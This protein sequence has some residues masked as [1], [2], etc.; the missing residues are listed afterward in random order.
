MWLSH[1]HSTAQAP[2]HGRAAACGE[3]TATHKLHSLYKKR[4]QAVMGFR[5]ATAA[6]TSSEIAPSVIKDTIICPQNV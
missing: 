3:A 4:W 6:A 1:P 2:A 5:Y